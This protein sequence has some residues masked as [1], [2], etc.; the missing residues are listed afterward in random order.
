MRASDRPARGAAVLDRAISGLNSWIGRVV[1]WLILPVV[2]VQFA[3]VLL[4]YVFGYGMVAMDEA[5]LFMHATL[6]MGA[7]AYALAADS[8]V[9]VDIFYGARGPRYRAWVDGLGVLLLLWPVCAFLVWIGWGYVARSWRIFEGSGTAGG[10]PGVFLIK[11]W[12]LAL[13]VLL[14]LQGLAVLTRAGL[15]LAGHA[16][17]MR[18]DEPP[19]PEEAL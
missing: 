14:A 9:R 15:V 18:P 8:H 13:P 2:V 5:I 4:R 10:L 3:I 11:T 6:F 7:G 17:D 19:A 12:I 1:A 16:R